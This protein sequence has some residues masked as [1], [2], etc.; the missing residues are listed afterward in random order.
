MSIDCDESYEEDFVDDDSSIE[1]QKMGKGLSSESEGRNCSVVD[2]GNTVG[3]HHKWQTE[4]TDPCGPSSSP[5]VESI[6]SANCSEETTP[7]RD[8]VD[9]HNSTSSVSPQKIAGECHKKK[10]SRKGEN[11][12]QQLEA[13]N[14]RLAAVSSQRRKLTA[15][16]VSAPPATS[17]KLPHIGRNHPSGVRD[18]A[19]ASTIDNRA[20]RR[21]PRAGYAALA[22][23]RLDYVIADA[24]VSPYLTNPGKKY[25]NETLHLPDVI[26]D[27]RFQSHGPCATNL[28]IDMEKCRSQFE[29]E[30]LHFRP[31]YNAKKKNIAKKQ[32]VMAMK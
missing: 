27:L 14:R 26:R 13:L 18:D 32:K 23:P 15:A 20:G 31:E 22:H 16:K 29:R 17:L 5:Q 8:A 2:Y 19:S 21:R 11:I 30:V 3:Q 4:P 25:S 6:R 9:G 10:K 24:C 12:D 1:Y 7:P 28:P